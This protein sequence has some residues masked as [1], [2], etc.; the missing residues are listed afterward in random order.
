MPDDDLT[1]EIP[2]PH[3]TDGPQQPVDDS[4]LEDETHPTVP[5]EDD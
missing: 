4:E 5:S 1:T 3:E 2:P